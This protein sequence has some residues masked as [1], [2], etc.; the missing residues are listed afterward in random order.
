M[1]A[2]ALS[3]VC[4]DVCRGHSHSDVV[5][6]QGGQGHRRRQHGG[7]DEADGGADQRSDQAELARDRRGRDHIDVDFLLV[8]HEFHIQRRCDR[9]G[10]GV[11]I[12]RCGIQ[13]GNQQGR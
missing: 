7:V 2:P 10:N 5:R 3:A 8:E 12:R 9:I 6:V 1:A 13:A 4:C 11:G